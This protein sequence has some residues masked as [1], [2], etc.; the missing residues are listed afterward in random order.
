MLCLQGVISLSLE[1]KLY[2]KQKINGGDTNLVFEAAA[3]AFDDAEILLGGQV[4][5]FIG[6]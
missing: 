2:Y 5:I 4:V 3:D 1:I 6:T